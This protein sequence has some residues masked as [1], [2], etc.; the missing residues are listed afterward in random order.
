M[1]LPRSDDVRSLVDGTARGA[2]L[3]G[4]LRD[5]FFTNHSMLGLRRTAGARSPAAAA[6]TFRRCSAPRGA[7]APGRTRRLAR[8]HGRRSGGSRP[9]GARA[10]STPPSSRRARRG[11]F[12]LSRIPRTRSGRSSPPSSRPQ[13]RPFSTPTRLMLPRRPSNRSSW[14]YRSPGC[15]VYADRP[16]I[17]Y[18]LNRL[19]R[20][21]PPASTASRSTAPPTSR[22]RHV[23]RVIEYEH[24]KVT[25]ASLAAAARAGR[26]GSSG[27]PHSRGRGRATASTRT[28][29]TRACGPPPRSCDV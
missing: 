19:Q 29:L 11:R 4:L 13:T 25:F 14:N 26:M 6:R 15:G 24:P 7:G 1:A 18:S 9:S 2:R 5:R 21:E 22:P 3:P 12:R 8:P 28:A 16:S 10:I 23:I 20:L 17:T 27:R